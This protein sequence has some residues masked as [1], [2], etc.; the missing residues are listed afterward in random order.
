MALSQKKLQQKRD[1]KNRKKTSNRRRVSE[2]G[3]LS[4]HL[5]NKVKS[6]FGFSGNP[7]GGPVNDV[8]TLLDK[9]YDPLHAVYVS[10]QNIISKVTEELQGERSI[11]EWLNYFEKAEREYMPVGPP[12]S[13]LTGSFFFCWIFFDVLFTFQGKKRS[14]CEFVMELNLDETL[15]KEI[16]AAI[17]ILQR[18]R[19]GIYEHGGFVD[20]R[21]VLTDIGT[22]ERF[23]CQ[24]PVAHKGREGE[25]WYVRILPP[26]DGFDY[27]VVFTT[28][29][30]L[31]NFTKSNW[32]AYIDRAVGRDDGILNADT[33]YNHFKYGPVRNY[34]SEYVFL[35]YVSHTS[36]AVF[37]TGLPDQKHTLPH[38]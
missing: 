6:L 1:R 7:D 12:M 28:P 35:A 32:L 26:I 37:L 22:G 29:Y 2:G 20:G 8:Q 4:G 3:I 10:A 23:V 33:Y 25:L 9:G 14:I 34:W 27:H 13:P 16:G 30:I 18:S 38:A 31:L 5:K 11:R 15:G 21:S 36:E 19:M 17:K 24:V